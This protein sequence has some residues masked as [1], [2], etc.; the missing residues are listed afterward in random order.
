M[1]RTIRGDGHAPVPA[2]IDALRLDL[3]FELEIG[4]AAGQVIDSDTPAHTKHVTFLE[5]YVR[6]TPTPAKSGAE[7]TWGVGISSDVTAAN[8]RAVISA[9]N[10]LAGDRP[11]LCPKRIFAQHPRVAGDWLNHGVNLRTGGLTPSSDQLEEIF[12][13]TLRV[14]IAAQN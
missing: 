11:F 9:A 6:G 13:S 3:G 5:M 10:V 2:L 4:E 1:E 12:G 7:T 14:Q 8:C